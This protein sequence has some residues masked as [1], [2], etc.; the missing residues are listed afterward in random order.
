MAALD[1]ER[2]DDEPTSE[3]TP[4][5]SG[6]CEPRDLPEG[7]QTHSS[8]HHPQFF[9]VASIIITAVFLIEMSDYMIKAPLMRLLEDVICRSYYESAE[10]PSIDLSIPIPEENCKLPGVQSQLAMLKGW[11]T[12]ISC[13][14]G[15]LLSV[16]YGVLADKH[17][18]KLVLVLAL[19]GIMLSLLWGLFV[20]EF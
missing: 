4:L 6:G 14:P 15:L 19:G 20:S 9:R 12:V 13:I 17:G 1:Y 16:P 3:T 8:H 10:P 18:R 2:R 7:G 5:V 11:D